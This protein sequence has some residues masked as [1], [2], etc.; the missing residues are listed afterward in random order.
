MRRRAEDFIAS[1]IASATYDWLKKLLEAGFGAT[2][3][4]WVNQWL[5]LVPVDPWLMAALSFFGLYCI[6]IFMTRQRRGGVMAAEDQAKQHIEI[7]GDVDGD[8]AGGNITKG[9]TVTTHHQSG[10]VATGEYHQ[11]G[12]VPLSARDFDWSAL[13]TKLKGFSGESIFI[14]YPMGNSQSKQFAK[15]LGGALEDAEIIVGIYA[16][17]YNETDLDVITIRWSSDKTS[18]PIEKDFPPV[19]WV[20]AQCLGSWGFRMAAQHTPLDDVPR[21][22][23]RVW[24]GDAEQILAIRSASN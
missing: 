21:R 19:M 22:G 16:S 20:L 15:R 18:P 12:Q 6:L 1:I 8:V 3:V 17:D 11:Y 7:G 5:S 10:G 9:H 14:H 13:T 23:N 24:I 4:T 2:I